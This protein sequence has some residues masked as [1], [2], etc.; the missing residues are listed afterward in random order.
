MDIEPKDPQT[1]IYYSKRKKL[2]WLLCYLFSTAIVIGVLAT[3]LKPAFSFVH[4]F[5]ALIALLMFLMSLKQIYDIWSNK[6]LLIISKNGIQIL[7]DEMDSWPSISN[8]KIK[9]TQFKTK[10]TR[11]TYFNGSRTRLFDLTD[12][13]VTG[14]QLAQLMKHYRSLNKHAH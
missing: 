6:P 3:A 12:S 9:T 11:L 10:T 7:P 14:D 5:W 1:V 8:E 13:T 2:L 4:L